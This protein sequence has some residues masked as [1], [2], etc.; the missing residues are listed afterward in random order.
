MFIFNWLTRPE[1]VYWRIYDSVGAFRSE[2]ANQ[3]YTILGT[4]GVLSAVYLLW[5]Y[6][7]VMLDQLQKKRINDS[8]Q[9]QRL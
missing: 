6:Q 2:L 3:T 1:W 9:Y 8:D 7:R 5:M 4:S